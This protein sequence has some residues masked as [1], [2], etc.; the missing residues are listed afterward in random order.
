MRFLSLI[1]SGSLHFNVS[2]EGI[3]LTPVEPGTSFSGILDVAARIIASARPIP[4]Y[5]VLTA[6]KHPLL[7]SPK[8]TYELDAIPTPNRF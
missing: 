3:I 8:S 6:K 4:F 2:Y 7:R 5:I 1:L